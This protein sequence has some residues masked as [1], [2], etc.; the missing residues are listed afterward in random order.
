MPAKALLWNSETQDGRWGHPEISKVSVTSLKQHYLEKCL[1][2]TGVHT[3]PY[4]LLRT[5][6]TMCRTWNQ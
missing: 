1:I 3:K 6:V 2:L 4:L 5:K